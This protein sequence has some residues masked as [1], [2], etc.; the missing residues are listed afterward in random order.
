[1][2]TKVIRKPTELC[3]PYG[4]KTELMEPV[5]GCRP[6]WIKDQHRFSARDLQL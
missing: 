6:Q 2:W 3:R 1:M 5:K 4:Q